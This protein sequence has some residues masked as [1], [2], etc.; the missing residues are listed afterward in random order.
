MIHAASLL[1]WSMLAAAVA[2][3]LEADV[4]AVALLGGE[5]RLVSAA[6]V[7]KDESAVLTLENPDAFDPVSAKLRVVLVGAPSGDV[8]AALAAMRWFK[9]AAP[10]ALRQRWS[11]SALPLADFDDGD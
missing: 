2:A 8:R 5:P 3:P 9:T 6:G 4:R 1:V 10:R 11:L 7:R